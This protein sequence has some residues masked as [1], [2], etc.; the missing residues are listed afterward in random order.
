MMMMLCSAQGSRHLSSTR[1]VVR[2]CVVDCRRLLLAQEQIVCTPLSVCL[3]VCLSV[4][5]SVTR[6]PSDDVRLFNVF[7][8][9]TA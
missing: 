1:P 9:V 3:Y 2:R 8:V 4:S 6:C 7:R 5:L